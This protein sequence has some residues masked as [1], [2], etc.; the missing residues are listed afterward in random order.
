[1]RDLYGKC[2]ARDRRS[3][4]QILDSN[5]I[6]YQSYIE[7]VF[8]SH[9]THPNKRELTFDWHWLPLNAV[10]TMTTEHWVIDPEADS[11]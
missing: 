3:R 10:T 1:M 5:A 2:G 4:H 9:E 11:R 8:Q 7:N 6:V